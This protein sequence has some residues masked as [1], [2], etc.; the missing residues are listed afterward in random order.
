MHEIKSFLSAQVES[1]EKIVFD[2]TLNALKTVDVEKFRPIVEE[3]KVPGSFQVSLSVEDTSGTTQEINPNLINPKTKTIRCADGA[4]IPY[5][6]GEAGFIDE[7]R[8][9]QSMNRKQAERLAQ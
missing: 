4:I 3:S 5:G 2:P 9:R 7:I 6:S 1:E 8:S